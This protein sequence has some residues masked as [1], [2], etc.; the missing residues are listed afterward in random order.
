MFKLY[1]KLFKV[2]DKY[3]EQID[4][5]KHL[6]DSY[7]VANNSVNSHDFLKA[8]LN[9]NNDLPNHINMAP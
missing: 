6:R 4:K 8:L 3:E 2:S 7:V 9:V 1:E 5:R